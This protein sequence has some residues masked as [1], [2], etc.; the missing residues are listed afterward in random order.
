MI[1]SYLRFMQCVFRPYACRRGNGCPRYL[2]SRY[3]WL[4]YAV[5]H[6]VWRCPAISGACVFIQWYVIDVELPPRMSFSG[7]G[8]H[9]FHNNPIWFLWLSTCKTN[10]R[11]KKKRNIQVLLFG[12][13]PL[14]R[15]SRPLSTYAHTHMPNPSMP[16]S[17]MF[18]NKY[19]TLYQ[20]LFSPYTQYVP[21]QA[22]PIAMFA[23]KRRIWF[24]STFG[25]VAMEPWEKY[26]TGQCLGSL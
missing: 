6:G 25:L 20:V 19:P 5:P 10:V 22:S 21:P 9:M 18:S 3:Y 11:R 15:F 8:D 7:H 13:V 23:W 2:L 14:I 4:P 24:E 12:V 26:I 16:R 1:Q 17:F